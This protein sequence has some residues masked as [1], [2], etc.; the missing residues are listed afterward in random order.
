MHDYTD[1]ELQNISE[2]LN[3]HCTSEVEIHLADCEVRQDESSRKTVD[4]PAVF[5]Q[6]NNCSFIIVKLDHNLFQGR[7]FYTPND[8]FGEEHQ[9]Y[10]DAGNCVSALLQ[11]QADQA[12]E[13]HRVRSETSSADLD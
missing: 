3:N 4:R 8:Q 12:Q 2:I 13:V 11:S 6:V 10:A 9:R 1:N 5:W 7:Y